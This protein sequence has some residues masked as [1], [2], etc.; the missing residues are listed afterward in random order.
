M[1]ASGS[2]TTLLEIALM[3]TLSDACRQGGARRPSPPLRSFSDLPLKA[4]PLIDAARDLLKILGGDLLWGGK[5]RP[6]GSVGC[7]RQQFIHDHILL[8]HYALL[9]ACPKPA[10]TRPNY[11][12]QNP[13]SMSKRTG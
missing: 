3:N 1:H 12:V 5:I 4:R 10:G 11:P 9:R 7:S 13:A 6:S 8:V 2:L